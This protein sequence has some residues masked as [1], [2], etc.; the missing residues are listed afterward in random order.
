VATC[1]HGVRLPHKLPTAITS[2]HQHS[3]AYSQHQ[4]APAA[5]GQGWGPPCRGLRREALARCRQIRRAWA[6]T[7]CIAHAQCWSAGSATAVSCSRFLRELAVFIPRNSGTEND[8]DS[9]APGKREP[10]NPHP[11]SD[12]FSLLALLLGLGIEMVSPSFVH[13]DIT[14]NKLRWICVEMMYIVTRSGQTDLL[15]LRRQHSWYPSCT[16]LPVPRHIR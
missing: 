1:G 10:G 15:V 9:R 4:Q 8:R 2:F 7:C 6:V 11:K 13:G 16:H 12:M 14:A 5:G 3:H